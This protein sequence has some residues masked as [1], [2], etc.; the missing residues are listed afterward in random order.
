MPYPLLRLILHAPSVSSGTTCKEP[1]GWLDLGGR[2][3]REALSGGEPLRTADRSS[4]P[5]RSPRTMD[6]L[7]DMLLS[8]V[9]RRHHSRAPYSIRGPG[10]SSRHAPGSGRGKLRP[11]GILA[12][13]M[14]V[15]APLASGSPIRQLRVRW[16]RFFG[17]GYFFSYISYTSYTVALRL[18]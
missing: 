18:P 12:L 14:D 6:V 15:G 8:R 16:N 7:E 13:R 17:G 1:G 11:Q 4:P 5:R 9:A 10:R 3:R 2:P